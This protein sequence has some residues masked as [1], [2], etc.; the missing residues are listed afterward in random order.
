MVLATAYTT[1]ITRDLPAALASERAGDARPLARLIA[2]AQGGASDPSSPR[3]YSEALYVAITCHDYPQAWDVRLPLAARARQL[4]ASRRTLPAA[5]FSPFSADAW[6]ADS[7]EGVPSC[8]D[9]PVPTGEPLLPPDPVAPLV[10]TLVLSGDLDTITPQPEGRVVAG[11][12][13]NSTFVDV[14][15]AVHVTALSDSEDCSSRIA[16]RFVRTLAAGDTSC[17]GRS[18]EVRIT[19][20]FPLALGDVSAPAPIGSDHSTVSARRLA[21]ALALTV[22]DAQSR[23]QVNYSGT[24]AGLRGGTISA[25]GDRLVRFTLRRSEFVPGI[26]VSGSVTWNRTRG[27]LHGRVTTP[28]DPS[29]LAL[30]WSMH[31]PL[32]RAWLTGL[33]GVQ[34]TMLAP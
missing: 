20:R 28:L 23:W 1:Q 6:T 26:P 14:H 27:T 4:A 29:P 21:A 7:Y 34:A 11:R 18:A 17:A 16:R 12:F 24:I 32:R 22:G 33:T 5:A 8:L 9:W 15:N 10:P 30:G 2:E 31:G 25:E 13:P 19:E 3:D